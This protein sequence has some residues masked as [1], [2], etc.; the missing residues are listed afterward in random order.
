MA[1]QGGKILD[2]DKR[3]D[4]YKF[5]ETLEF[6]LLHLPRPDEVIF[7][8]MPY[9]ASQ[10]LKGTRKN[11][12]Q[13]ETSTENQIHAIKTYLELAKLYN[14]KQVNCTDNERIKSIEEIHEEVYK[15]AKK[16]I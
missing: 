10:K 14:F 8:Y 3:K 9:E 1:H 15:L 2:D 16:I 11:L 7:L 6:E 12:D 5:L 13:H 4:M